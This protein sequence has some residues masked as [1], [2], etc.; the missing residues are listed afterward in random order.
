MQ[1]LL[2]HAQ[3]DDRVGA[4]ERLFDARRA[5]RRRAE[6]LEFARQPHGRSA[7]SEAAAE[8]AEQVKIGT[9]HAAV[10]QV[11]DDRDVEILDVAEAI[12]DGERVEERLRGMLM[13]AIAGIDHG[14]IQMAGHEI[15]GA[16]RSCGA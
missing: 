1:A 10:Q 4:L 11:A 8:F 6:A 14:N 16:G 2:L 9:R 12:A 15:R 5:A 13:G 7:E 3:N